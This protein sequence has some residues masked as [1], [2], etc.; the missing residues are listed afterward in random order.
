ME[1]RFLNMHPFR[2][3]IKPRAGMGAGRNRGGAALPRVSQGEPEEILDAD[4]PEPPLVRPRPLFPGEG[5]VQRFQMRLEA[6]VLIPQKVLRAAL[7]IELGE[8][9][10]FPDRLVGRGEKVVDAAR[11]AP[12]RAEKMVELVSERRD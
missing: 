12:E 2:P 9:L 5:N 10:L 3:E 11:D 6:A 8:K 1:N 4:V 7:E